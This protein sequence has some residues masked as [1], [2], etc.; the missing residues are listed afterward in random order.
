MDFLYDLKGNLVFDMDEVLVN[1]F[2]T[3][4]AYYITNQKKFEEYISPRRLTEDDMDGINNRKNSDLRFEL[5]KPEILS[6]PEQK[7]KEVLKKI[8][9][10]KEDKLYWKSDIYKHLSPTDLGRTLMYTSV[11]D[12]DDIKSV[13]IL[14]Y[15]SSDELNRH[16]QNFVDRYF[17]HPKIKMVPVNGFGRDSKI[18]K[19]DV[20]KKTGIDWDVFVDD[21][22]YNIM[23]FAENYDNIKDK[24]FLMPKFG[25]NKLTQEQLDYIS[26]KGAILQYYVP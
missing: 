20:M 12:K 3:V 23:D 16:K 19:S 22:P 9:N 2:P 5:L 24:M 14:T 4:Y 13:T 10:S 7:L 26:N 1:I 25:Y 6:L 17:K 11:I 18:K 15:S 21:M 8:K